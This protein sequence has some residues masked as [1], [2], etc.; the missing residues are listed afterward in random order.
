MP[1]AYPVKNASVVSTTDLSQYSFS[2]RNLLLEG[3]VLVIV[4]ESWLSNSAGDF[5]M[6]TV[7][8]QM[9]DVSDRAAPRLESTVQ[10]EGNYLAARMV[11]GRAYLVIQ[12]YPAWIVVPADA[13]SSSSSA[14]SQKTLRSASPLFRQLAPGVAGNKQLRA[15]VGFQ[16]LEKGCSNIGHL[17]G[18]G[19]S[20]EMLTVFAMDAD[21]ARSTT[22]GTYKSVTHAGR[23]HIVYVST[24]RIYVA[25]TTY[26]YQRVKD[27]AEA[28]ST[29]TPKP[30]RGVWSAILAFDINR[31]VSKQVGW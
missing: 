29:D 1:R 30:A 2:P 3:D 11:D 22:Y 21:K 27:P 4:G 28:P 13:S 23:G 16:A 5:S 17:T 19:V 25:S 9:W 8:Q 20:T 7:V 14:S 31:Y 15:A 18:L 24:Q 6:S 10:L 12:T 26:D